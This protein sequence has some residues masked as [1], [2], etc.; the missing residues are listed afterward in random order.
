[1]GQPLSAGINEMPGAGRRSGGAPA[2]G[3]AARGV[4]GRA[5]ARGRREAGGSSTPCRPRSRRG[6][7]HRET[8]GRRGPPRS[9]GGCCHLAAAAAA[10]GRTRHPGRRA[11]PGRT[12]PLRAARESKGSWKARR[13]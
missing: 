12:R 4:S 6:D 9:A 5:R 1:M 3:R 2:A 8:A 13:E 7:K 10:W 11:G